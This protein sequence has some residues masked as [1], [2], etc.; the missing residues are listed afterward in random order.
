MNILI[1][2]GAGYIGSHIAKQLLE[3]TGY[4]IIILDNLSTSSI[5]RVNT[6]KAIRKFKF[7]QLD[8]SEVSA[9]DE[10][11]KTNEIDTIIHVAGSIIVSE[12]VKKP[13]KYYMNN[14]VNTI[15]LINS[16]SRNKVGK[17]IF[18]ST[19]AV[20]GEPDQ[21]S[22]KG[23]EE[24]CKKDPI[25]PYGMSKLMGEQVLQDAA[26]S[27]ANLKYVIFRYFNAAGADI[28]Y[29]NN[30]LAPR[31]GQSTP[32]ATHLIKIASECASFVREKMYIFGN[33][34]ATK[35][36]TCI[37]DYVHIDDLAQAHIKAISYLDSSDSDVFNIG[38]NSGYSVK[39]VIEVMKQ[40]AGVD[41]PVYLTAKRYGD[42]PFLIANN[43]K[44]K[45]K[46]NWIPQYEDL[47]LICNS[48]Y[49]WQCNKG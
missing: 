15:N 39:D 17:F 6:L 25:N 16:A 22:D 47:H 3:N 21:P 24:N 8:L 12:S 14:T 40:V 19:A 30:T 2:G 27:D 28:H 32:N 1:T 34:Y 33:D 23:I 10:V 49:K 9:V 38:Y 37:R 41:F 31:I 48:A 11:I 46:M 5:E 42:P 36:G 45:S 44:I 35:D 20:Y 13:L 7:V 29:V 18:S 4:S 26:A 43:D